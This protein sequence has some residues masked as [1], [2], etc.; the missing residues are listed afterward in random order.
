MSYD[1]QKLLAESMQCLLYKEFFLEVGVNKYSGELNILW[2]IISNTAKRN[3]PESKDLLAEFQS[4]SSKLINDLKDFTNLRCS[5]KES[6]KFRYHFLK[7]NEITLH[8][9]RADREG[10][11]ELPLDAMQC[12]LFEFTL[13]G[14]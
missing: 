7:R 8:L 11:W 6:F 9:P 5:T 14:Q 12:V 13:L 4:I 3:V 1:A 10:S 2:R